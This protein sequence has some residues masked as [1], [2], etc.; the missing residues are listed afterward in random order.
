MDFSSQRRFGFTGACWVLVGAPGGG[1]EGWS[2]RRG[3]EVPLP[4]SGEA[5]PEG[6]LLVS[7]G[8]SSRSPSHGPGSA[9]PKPIHARAP[10]PYPPLDSAVPAPDPL[11]S[12]PFH[13]LLPSLALFSH[14]SPSLGALRACHASPGT[15]W[16]IPRPAPA[17]GMA[18]PPPLSRRCPQ[19]PGVSV[20]V[21]S[22]GILR[23]LQ[24]DVKCIESREDAADGV[25]AAP[26]RWGDD[27]AARPRGQARPGAR[28]LEV[29]PGASTH[30]TVPFP[31]GKDK[32]G[33]SLPL[34]AAPAALLAA[35]RLRASLH[36]HLLPQRPAERGERGS[37]MG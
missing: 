29:F 36:L 34:P 30:G 21:S 24:S 10:A 15:C 16:S 2:R 35:G 13:P 20:W 27:G 11:P 31:S 8:F 22:R 6:A 25:S 9:E 3:A 17:A 1:G 14:L 4:V 18:F 32:E 5:H 23:L 33:A 28:R 12:I 7:S 26:E 19:Q 37:G